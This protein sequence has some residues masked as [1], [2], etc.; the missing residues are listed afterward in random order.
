VSGS[1]AAVTAQAVEPRFTLGEWSR[2]V[3]DPT[4][5]KAYQSVTRLGG[6][7]GRY[8]AWKR[9]EAAA[10]SLVIYE[11]YLA[12]LCMHLATRYGDPDVHEVTP[13]MLLDGAQQHPLGSYGIVRT[14]YRGFFAWAEDWENVLPNPARRLPKKRPQPARVYEIF[15]A[16]EQAQLARAS[17]R[18][19]LPWVQRLRV[20]AFVDLGIRSEEARLM[21][22]R[23]V[24]TTS[25]VVVVKGKGGKERVVPFGIEFFRAFVGYRNRPIPNVRMT[26]ERGP[27]RDTRPPLDDDYLFF[28]LGF[29]RATG[30]VT[31]ADPF[32]P[33]SD[34]G[35]R[36]W[37]DR[38]VALSG[39]KYRSLHMNRHT[40]G[41]NLSDAGEGLETIQDW[42]GHAD[43]STTKVYVHN[44]RTRLQ[45]GRG[46]LDDWRKAQE[47]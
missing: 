42:L 25:R 18:M 16:A 6:A 36:S 45:R 46:A 41:T 7:V 47:S 32:R 21:R 11:G 28:P 15:S 2:I 14:S 27:Y 39:V 23:D 10:R 24:D 38:V 31:W 19:A 34:R 22:P 29:V 5:D 1:R 20:L 35:M 17:D 40:L 44:S 4:K 3:S 8:L 33:L 13:E 26:D 9:P 12:D 43:P 37:W 30:A